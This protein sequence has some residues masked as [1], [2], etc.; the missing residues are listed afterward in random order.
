MPP[1]PICLRDGV[2]Q[3]RFLP[4]PA[5]GVAGLLIFGVPASGTGQSRGT[6]SEGADSNYFSGSTTSGHHGTSDNTEA[7]RRDDVETM[8]QDYVERPR[9]SARASDETLRLRIREAL[10]D[11]YSLGPYANRIYIGVDG[12]E[13][14]LRGPV[15][16]EKD[17]A[18]IAAHTRR[19]AGVTEIH[20][21]LQVA[22]NFSGYTSGSS[23]EVPGHD[24]GSTTFRRQSGA[25]RPGP[26]SYRPIAVSEREFVY[27]SQFDQ[28]FSPDEFLTQAERDL[29]KRVAVNVAIDP[30]TSRMAKVVTIS[31]DQGTVTLQGP[32][33][34]ERARELLIDKVV[35]MPGVLRVRDGLRVAGISVAEP[36]D[37][38]AGYTGTGPGVVVAPAPPIDRDVLAQERR[39]ERYDG[40]P[41]TQS[42][43]AADDEA[44]IGSGEMHQEDRTGTTGPSG[45][46]NTS[47]MDTG[48]VDTVGR[49]TKSFGDE[50]VTTNDRAL[51]SQVRAALTVSPEFPAAG[52]TVHLKA[53]NGVI[54]L[55]GW[56]ASDQERQAMAA[57][58]RDVTGV[59]DVVNHL[60]V[61]SGPV[62]SVR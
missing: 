47:P 10:E 24:A 60:Q 38:V 14:T 12:G 55:H 50:A 21:Q 39:S 3:H 18:D 8:N 27:R 32:V 30:A 57:A 26:T 17:K 1:S 4:W 13:V 28:N 11:D 22:P 40:F 45:S 54:H 41:A 23:E 34:T 7:F 61:R 53:D 31:V 42:S 16:T 2:M 37:R 6:S 29:V 15:K 35:G 9:T 59:Q 19:V 33:P 46:R 58:V 51:V 49:V 62:G 44:L 56:V 25:A 52:G 43:E 48:A 5:V 20:N 36:T